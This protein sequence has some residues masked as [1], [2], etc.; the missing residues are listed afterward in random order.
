MA[1]IL[2]VLRSITESTDGVFNSGR[3]VLCWMQGTP[4]SLGLAEHRAELKAE[5]GSM[6][7][8]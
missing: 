2:V 1:P 3:V 7:V 6:H 5:F 8:T 4:F